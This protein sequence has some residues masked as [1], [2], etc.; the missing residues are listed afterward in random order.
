MIIG[1][2]EHLNLVP[3]LPAKLQHAIE[4]IRDNVNSNTPTGKYEIEGEKVFFM[5]SENIPRQRQDANPEYHK[6]YIDIQI[7]LEGEEGMAISTL[8][9]HTE[10]T[11]DNI[12]SGDI[13]FVK[14]PDEETIFVAHQN[15]FVIFYPGEVHKPLC[16]VD[17]KLA[18]VRKVVVKVDVNYL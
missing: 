7:V 17:G 5:V 4:Y 2:I 6:K 3:Y 14:T 18:K 15:D 13:A 8:A 12:A 10:I 9:P 1:N 16:V 11:E